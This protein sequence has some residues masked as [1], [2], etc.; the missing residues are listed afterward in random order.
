M[1]T[2]K[3]PSEVIPFIPA[4]G[5]LRPAF[6]QRQTQARLHN[7]SVELAKQDHDL[8]ARRRNQPKEPA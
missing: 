4:M 8:E 6:V 2:T 5:R 3:S 7:R 1:T